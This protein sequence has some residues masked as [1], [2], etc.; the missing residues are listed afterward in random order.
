[1]TGMSHMKY[2]L[3]GG[4]ALFV[5]LLAFGVAP[6]S[7]VFLAI[8][9]ACPLMMVFMMGGHSGHDSQSRGQDDTGDQDVISPGHRHH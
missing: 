9:L 4:G 6:Q 2:M 1:M 8:A 5:V 3:L 7:A